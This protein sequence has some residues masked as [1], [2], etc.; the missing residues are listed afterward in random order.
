MSH[1]I[2]SG[3]INPAKPVIKEEENPVDTITLDVP[4]LIRLLELAKED[5]KSDVELHSVVERII[6]LK[7]NGVLSMQDY[8]SIIQPQETNQVELEAIK[9]LA[10]I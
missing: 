8:D 2:H 5:I 4:L 1:F 3:I 10:G 6:S 9:K 7:N